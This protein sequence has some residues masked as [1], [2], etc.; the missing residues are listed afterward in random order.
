MSSAAPCIAVMDAD[1][2]HDE[3]LL[4]A[5]LARMRDGAVAVDVVV[6]SRHVEGGSMGEFGR[7]RTQLSQMG[8]RISR[9]VCRCDVSDAMSGYF[10][11][12]AEFFR[13]TVPR[14]TGT[15]FKILV[16]ILASS[17]TAPR[18]AEVPYR[19]R[20]RQQGES[21]LDA[22]VQLEYLYLIVDKLVGRWIPTRFAL[23]LGVGALGVGVH[24]AVLVLLYGRLS[25]GQA[26]V[27]ATVVAMTSNFLLNNVATFRNRRL[28]GARL[29]TGL[30]KFYVAC[31]LGAVINVV[32][33][34][35][36]WRVTIEDT[37][38]RLTKKP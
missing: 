2:Q 18:V 12:E 33:D 3:T 30:M 10:L 9:L 1:L 20:M 6:A 4:P 32:S 22:N 17:K 16:D 25:F 7:G 27:A 23:F 26:Q 38:I 5:M 28:R 35:A 31:S 19:F 21:K 15:G 14:L 37:G 13:A 11:V 34:S 29:V 8:R 24:L 36:G